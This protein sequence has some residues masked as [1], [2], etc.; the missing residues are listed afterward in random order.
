M[1]A[2]VH[3]YLRSQDI[4]AEK[5]LRILDGAV[6]VAFSGKIDNN[7]RFFLFKKLKD[8][9]AVANVGFLK[10]ESRIPHNRLQRGEIAGIGQLVKTHDAIVRMFLQ[11]VK[12]KIRS[13]ESGS[14]S[15]ENIHDIHLNKKTN[16]QPLCADAPRRGIY[17]RFRPSEE[18]AL[19]LSIFHNRQFPPV[20]K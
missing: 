12:D 9:F 13:Y 10:T 14:A 5:N 7:I 4:R 20:R 15:H 6:N 3:Q 18:A 1:P 8:S 19:W 11:H 17:H 16:R 2:G